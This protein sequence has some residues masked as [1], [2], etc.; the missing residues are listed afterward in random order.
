MYKFVLEL[1]KY[2]FIIRIIICNFTV[3]MLKCE[4]K[5]EIY[6]F[7]WKV[8]VNYNAKMFKLRFDLKKKS[9]WKLKDTIYWENNSRKCTQQT[10][11]NDLEA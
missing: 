11:S 5:T 3:T 6:P 4:W 9:K 7:R 10:I 1:Y 8:I 2:I